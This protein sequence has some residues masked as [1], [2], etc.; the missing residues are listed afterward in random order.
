MSRARASA[1]GAGRLRS[2]VIVLQRYRLTNASHFASEGIQPD[3]AS[4]FTRASTW[5]PVFSLAATAAFAAAFRTARLRF[6]IG[7][8][9][10]SAAFAGVIAIPELRFA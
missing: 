9:S 7:L 2:N 4:F 6:G 10:L 1:G 5:R 8:R 3:S